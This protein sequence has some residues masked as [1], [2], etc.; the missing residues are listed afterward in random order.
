MPIAKK[1]A[2]IDPVVVAQ[3]EEAES[4]AALSASQNERAQSEYDAEYI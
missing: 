2:K 1:M 4:A 3:I